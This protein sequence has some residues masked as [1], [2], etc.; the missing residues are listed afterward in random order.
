[1]AKL[2]GESRAY[3][4]GTL[5]AVLG[6]QHKGADEAVQNGHNDAGQNG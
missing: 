2:H 1:M 6:A 3:I 5:K 4:E